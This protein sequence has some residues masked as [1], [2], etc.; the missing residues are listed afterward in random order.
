LL[1]VSPVAPTIVL[2]KELLFTVLL[3]PLLF[4]ATLNIPWP[5]LR[6][7]F[8]VIVTLA[9]VGVALSAGVTS[10]GMHYL[11]HWAWPGAIVFGALIAA[12]DPVSVIAAF[13]EAK[14][15]GRL[16]MLIETESLFNDG[17]AA[18]A[19]AVAVAVASGQHLTSFA[20]V[21]MPLRMIGG[22]ILCGAAVAGSS[23]PARGAN[24]RP[25]G[26]DHIHNLGRLR[27][28]PA[29]SAFRFIR[30]IG[31]DHGRSDYREL[32]AARHHL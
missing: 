19:F 12:T 30:S 22:G 4:E 15:H 24:A 8:P 9:T 5:Q 32:S 2:T 31:D 17:T 27:V 3:P 6:R 7:D 18:V 25:F 16:L 1:A 23:S 21:S 10:A 14:A 26:G 11:A 13:R 28:F 29:G 20:V